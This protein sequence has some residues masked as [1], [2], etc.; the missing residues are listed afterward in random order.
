[1][2]FGISLHRSISVIYVA[3]VKTCFGVLVVCRSGFTGEALCCISTH[4]R[5]FVFCVVNMLWCGALSCS[6][7]RAR[8]PIFVAIALV[9]L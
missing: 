5:D 6:S 8:T 9:A 7:A 4:A 1:M 3:L 2:K